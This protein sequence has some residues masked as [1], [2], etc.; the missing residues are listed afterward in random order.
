[1]L[2]M[3]YK[4]LE[5]LLDIPVNLNMKPKKEIPSLKIKKEILKRDNHCCQLCGNVEKLSIH[6]II[7]NG[8][9]TSINLV[10][11][12]KYCHQAVHLMLYVEGKWRYVNYR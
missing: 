6:H 3:N 12:C 7:P 2:F 8:S 4:E 9:A 11:L 5:R 1:M 10:T